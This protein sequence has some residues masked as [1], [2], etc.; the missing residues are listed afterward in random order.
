M[1][2]TA[3]RIASRALHACV[4]LLGVV[5]TALCFGAGS[6]LATP[7]DCSGN[8]IYVAQRPVKT[9]GTIYELSTK[10]VG[11]ATATLTELTKMPAATANALG[12]SAG[13]AGLWA[14]EQSGGKGSA[15]VYGY[16]A[17]TKKWTTYVGYGGEPSGYVAG[18]VDPVNGIYYYADYSSTEA[19]LYGFDTI[20]DTAITGVI[21][22]F[23]LPDGTS[24]SQNGD[25]TFDLNGNLYALA[26]DGSKLGVGVVKAADVPSTATGAELPITVLSAVAEATKY[27]GIAFDNRGH[28]Y[29]EGSP[30]SYGVKEID[31]NNGSTLAAFTPYSNQEAPDVDLASCSPI[32]TLTAQVEIAKRAASTD[33]FKLSITGGTITQGNT[34]TTEGTST[35]LQSKVAGPVIGSSE[36]EYTY[37]Q[38]AASGSLENYDVTYSCVD[39]ANGAKAV[40]SGTGS[41]FKLKFPTVELGQ[42]EAP[43]AIVCTFD[44]QL[45]EADLG[46]SD[47]VEPKT[48]ADGGGVTYTLTVA[49]HGPDTA[50]E[51]KLTDVLPAGVSI[52]EAKTSQ[53]SCTTTS[54]LECKLGS[55]ANGKSVS[56]TVV[57]TVAA[58]SGT[59]TDSAHVEAEPNDPEL[60]NNKAN[61]SF[62]ATPSADLGVSDSVEPKTVADGGGVTYT[63]T[64]ADHG[65]DTATESKLTDVLPAGVSITEAKTSQGSCTTTSGLECKLGSIANGKSVSVTVVGTVAAS[66][67]TL[68]DSAHVEAEPNDPELANNKANASFKATPSADLGV[69]D[70]V[71]PKTVAD[72][73]GVTYTLTVAD[74]G[75]DTA[76]ESKLTDV[77]PAGVSITEAKT[78][79]GSCTTTSG[80][81]CKLGSIANGKSVSVTV[82]GTVAASSGTLTDSAHVEAEPNDPELANNKA[83]ASF[84]A[85]PSADLGVS[86]SVEPKTVADGGGV[87]YTLTVAD[88]GP[89]TATESKLTDVLPAGVSIT[90][91]KT[92]QG[93]CTTTSGL[94][95]KLGSIANGKSVS[96]TVVGTVAASSGTLTDSAHVEAEPNDPELAN[97]KANAS[98]KA[99]PSA[100]LGV[101]DSVEPKTVADGGGVTYTLTVADHGPDTATESKLTDVLPAGVSITEAKTSQGSCTTTS[102]LECKLG[103]IAN[104]KSVSVTVVGTVAASSGTLTDSAHVEAEPNDPELANNKA[105]ASFKATPSADLGV[106]DSVE[107]KT[108]ADGGGVTYTLTVADH[109]PDTATES[110]LTDVLPAG[111]SITEAKTSQGSCTTTSGLECKLGSI[112]N[113]KSVSVTVVGTV[114]ASSGTLTDSAHVEA[115]PNDPELANNKANA[116]FKATP[117][118]D[119]G[120]SDSVEPKTVADGGGVTYTLTVADH[121]PDTATESKL[122]D[123]LP[124]GV[125][126]TEA[127]TSQGSCTTTSGLECKLGSIANGKSVSVTVVGTV[128]AS[129]GTLTDSAHVEAEPNDPELANNKANASFKATPSADLGVSDSV[130][131]KTVADGG[132]VTYTLTVADHGPDTATESKLTDVLPAGVSITEAKTSQGS[133]TTTSGLECKLGSIANGKSVSVTVVGTVAA[134]S[135]TL[136]D[137]AHVEA[138]PND[139]ELANNK[140]NASFKAT[141]SADLGVSDSVEPRTTLAGS[142]VTYSL[143]V[144]NHGPDT[145]TQSKLTD[146]LPA[147]VAAANAFTSQGSCTTTSGL[148]CKLG[149]ILKGSSAKVTLTANVAGNTTGVLTDKA[150]TEAE[151]VDAELANNTASASFEIVAAPPAPEAPLAPPAPAAPAGKI[152]VAV[153]TRTD[154]LVADPDEPVTYTITVRNLGTEIAP[155]VVLVNSFEGPLQV[156]YSQTSRGTCTGSGLVTCKLGD[157]APG[158]V[159]TIEI[160]GVLRSRHDV[161]LKSYANVDCASASACPRDVNLKN[162]D[163]AVRVYPRPKIHLREIVE[164]RVVQAGEEVPITLRVSNP[165]YL[166]LWNTKTCAQL[167]LGLLFE[168]SARTASVHDGRFCWNLGILTKYRVVRVKLMTRSLA[169]SLGVALSHSVA[170]AADA[171]P[172]HSHGGVMIIAQASRGPS[173]VTG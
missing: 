144:T 84:K 52:T 141:P 10:T 158:E 30:S 121:G 56:V 20:T 115:E 122:T 27:N 77:L 89:D 102:G 15:T 110:K 71:E 69:S 104:G 4:A 149:T 120:V 72:G 18:A 76:T 32:P 173:A 165:S 98:F 35:G 40:A 43:P 117:S 48:V 108:V 112:A 160:T 171:A 119:L 36:T 49:D 91:A 16:E 113:G 28:L 134:S 99:T 57:G 39:M 159:I 29:L 26:S 142:Q 65:P 155:D 88:H 135:G 95:C 17:A 33:Q 34:A 1:S 100:D 62:K 147:G 168:H 82:V 83:N 73:G 47:S 67:G 169:G 90:E 58:S 161:R 128:A 92:S 125:S 111:V 164:R 68:T 6:A 63:L 124:A 79:Q 166:T 101:S 131:P 85:T 31:P 7:L 5:A 41:S 114:A 13:G 130:E 154:T 132:G 93:S 22:H 167:P 80:L 44:D 151:Q 12:A 107:P 54:G 81:E 74:H 153:A 97:N 126:I 118:A 156:R 162:N 11:G 64:V 59:L 51:S 66:S 152:D 109:G 8:T 127:K 123:V 9:E 103:S 37:T 133:C 150:H 94:E 129:S 45:K 2:R 138:E 25:F 42:A 24:G 105:N 75:P 38:T 23:K 170:T 46:V 106:S 163:D 137:S 78:S 172:G 61:A 140:A 145:A 116:S 96:V 70:S 60:A 148:E 53:G 3:S 136:T 146:T 14:V 143:T 55:I 86:D 139:P 21:G 50:T 157:L 87:T 19:T